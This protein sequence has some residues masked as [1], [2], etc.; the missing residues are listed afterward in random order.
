MQNQK[1]DKLR[2]AVGLVFGI[3]FGAVIWFVGGFIVVWLASV[4]SFGQLGISW[5]VLAVDVSAVAIL[6]WFLRRTTKGRFIIIGALL[7]FA[8]VLLIPNYC[9]VYSL[10]GAK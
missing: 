10:L 8:A 9:S 1:F 5:G 6:F 3:I 2:K 7:F 4:L